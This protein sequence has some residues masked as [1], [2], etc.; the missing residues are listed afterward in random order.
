MTR[1][2]AIVAASHDGVIVADRDGRIVDINATAGMMFG[3]SRV[4]AIGH[5]LGHVLRPDPGRDVE[6]GQPEAALA[7]RSGDQ[8]IVGQGR[9]R[10]R[11][12]HRDGILFPLELSISEAG[13]GPQG[14]YV[15]FLRDLTAEVAAEADL[16]TARDEALA[17]EK[18]KADLLAV[19][20]HEIRTPLNGL[21][22]TMDLLRQEG[23]R[24]HSRKLRS[25]DEPPFR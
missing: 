15:A 20:S 23:P 7:L 22:G 14:L 4:Q 11:A 2:S 13:S 5:S 3:Y 6:K 21:I 10:L 19:M 17:G 18:T 9:V 24:L 25:F 8:R 12:R 16:T 1:L